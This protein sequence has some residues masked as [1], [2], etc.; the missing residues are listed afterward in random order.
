VNEPNAFVDTMATNLL[1]MEKTIVS[2]LDK[3]T[4]ESVVGRWAKSQVG[5]GPVI[6]A[7][8]AA[9]IDITQSPTPGALQRYAGLD[10][11]AVWISAEKADVMVKALRAEH[12]KAKVDE[13]II[14]AAAQLGR[15]VES[16]TK[17]TLRLGEGKLTFAALVKAIS[18]RPWNAN[19]KV[20]CWKIG[21]SFCKFHNHKDC[22]YGHLYAEHKAKTIAKNAAGG[23]EDM[24]R[25]TLSAKTFKDKKTREIYE[26]G[27]I[28]DGRVESQ[29]RR[30]AVT[31]F[32]YH[33]FE[34]AYTAHYGKRPP[35]P[36]ILATQPDVH[37]HYIA[38]PLWIP[39]VR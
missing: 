3:A 9:Y 33:Y 14:L 7:G 4:D 13:I 35:K 24:A 27:H 5:I 21:D 31:M 30:K 2:A 34:V 36:Y 18:I 8:L 15:K 19:L 32:L 10:A 26:S 11:K 20:L 38:P 23:F 16:L 1:R 39:D 22:F 29:A 6:A 28:P 25:D 17:S 12:P 37:T